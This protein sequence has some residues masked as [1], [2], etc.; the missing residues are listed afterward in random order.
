MRIIK[1]KLQKMRPYSHDIIEF[2]TDGGNR[3]FLLDSELEMIFDKKGELQDADN[4][5][6]I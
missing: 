6:L 4:E 5:E 3:Y 2:E 1:V